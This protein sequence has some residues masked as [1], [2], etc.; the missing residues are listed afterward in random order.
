MKQETQELHAAIDRILR[1]RQKTA[2]LS[3]TR[4]GRSKIEALKHLVSLGI[5]VERERAAKG[6]F[7]PDVIQEMLPR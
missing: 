1:K 3:I 6:G 7:G 4:G 5:E 2:I